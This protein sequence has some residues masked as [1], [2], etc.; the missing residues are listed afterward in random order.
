MGYVVGLTGGIGSGKSVVSDCFK[1]RGVTIADADVAARTVVEPGTP[2]LARITEHF[3]AQ[4]LRPD[5]TLDRA[6]L[7]NIVF[8]SVEDRRWLESVTVP[9]IMSEL[10]DI[11]EKSTAAYS[12]LILSSGSGRSHLI[13]RS[14]VVDVPEDVQIARV[15]SRDN[16][17]VEQVR[18]IMNSQPTREQRL[19]YAD[20][21]IKNTGSLTELEA[22]VDGL[23]TKYL[24]LAEQHG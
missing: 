12:M 11:L 20:D 19:S 18:A 5:G 8:R 1:R 24:N 23:H 13:N 6:A 15:T 22:L 21:V 2:A 3:G 14:L 17:S 7:R 16:N 9:A 10:R 4:I